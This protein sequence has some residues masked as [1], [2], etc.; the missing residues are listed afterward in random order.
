MQ[1]FFVQRV[2]LSSVLWSTNTEG[3]SLQFLN[4]DAKR[5]SHKITFYHIENPLCKEL[6]RDENKMDL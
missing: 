1:A 4:Y 3:T 5:E 6:Q 2:V